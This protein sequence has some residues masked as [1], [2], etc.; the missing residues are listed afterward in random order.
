M[1]KSAQRVLG[2]KLGLLSLAEELGS[3][4]EACRM[5]GVSRDTYYRY[6]VAKQEGGVA[7]LLDQDR[8]RPN[9]Y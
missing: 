5:M 2:N 6:K 7:A 4:T 9:Q 8:R 3:V 1:N